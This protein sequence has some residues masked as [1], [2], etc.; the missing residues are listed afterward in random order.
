[1]PD[2]QNNL[3]AGER[4]LMEAQ[5]RQAQSVDPE[6]ERQARAAGFN[7]YAEMQAYMMQKARKTGGSRPAG[8]ADG[9][10]ADSGASRS[11]PLSWHPRQLLDYVNRKW[12]EH[13]R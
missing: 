2:R 9:P 3:T 11:N 8:G 12:N 6:L 5:Q 4:Q 1:M 13:V 7:S 10:M